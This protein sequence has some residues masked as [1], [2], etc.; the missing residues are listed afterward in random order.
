MMQ[1][2][3]DDP[4]LLFNRDSRAAATSAGILNAQV[5]RGRSTTFPEIRIRPSR[6]QGFNRS[7]TPRSHGPV[8]WCNST[9]VDRIRIR[10]GLDK[11]VD[12]GGLILRIPDVGVAGVVQWLCTSPVSG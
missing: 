5:E 1:E 3:A 4:L 2:N 12:G 9:L 11:T 8:D 10:R 7:R 6:Q